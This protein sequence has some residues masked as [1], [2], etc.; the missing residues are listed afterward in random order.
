MI[1]LNT[2]F[3][4]EEKDMLLRC[5]GKWYE[6]LTE[7]DGEHY[8]MNSCGEFQGN[9][10]FEPTDDEFWAKQRYRKLMPYR[11]I[12]FFHFYLLNTIDDEN[13]WYRGYQTNNGNWE[14]D[15][16]ADS[17]EDMFDSL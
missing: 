11:M 12:K 3:T 17:L 13:V 16:Y 7:V 15:C 14:Y 5:A 1:K 6:I 4:D 9:E 10:I 2:S 8:V